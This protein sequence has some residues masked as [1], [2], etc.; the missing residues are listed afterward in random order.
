MHSIAWVQNK[1]NDRVSYKRFEEKE[2]IYWQTIWCKVTFPSL[3]Q[4]K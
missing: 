1:K 3:Q 2:V 4:H